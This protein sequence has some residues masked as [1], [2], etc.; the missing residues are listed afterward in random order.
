[1]SK[2]SKYWFKRNII[3]GECVQTSILNIYI[4]IYIYSGL[5]CLCIL[6]SYVYI[7]V[8]RNSETTPTSRWTNVA[9]EPCMH[10]II[11]WHIG[12]LYSAEYLHLF[13][14]DIVK[15]ETKT[16]KQR[17]SG[18]TAYCCCCCCCLP[19]HQSIH[20]SIETRYRREWQMEDVQWI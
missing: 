10:C 5:L 14:T 6:L 4:Y 17:Q 15:H 13:I 16:K 2:Q 1:M 11:T 20:W 18:D 9:P 3:A 12:I 19:I 8:K 7:A